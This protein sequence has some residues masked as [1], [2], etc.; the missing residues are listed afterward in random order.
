MQPRAP[1]PCAILIYVLLKRPGRRTFTLLIALLAVPILQ[2]LFNPILLFSYRQIYTNRAI[3]LLWPFLSGLIYV[4]I[5]ALAYRAI[6]QT[7]LRPTPS[8]VILATVAMFF[9]FFFVRE[10]TPHFY[11]LWR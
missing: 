7:G 1:S 2:A 11:S 10:I 3:G 4:V 5:L 8:S 9:Y 6:E